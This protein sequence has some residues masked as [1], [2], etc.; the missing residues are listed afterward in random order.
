MD[1]RISEP[2][3]VVE[4]TVISRVKEKLKEVEVYGEKNVTYGP[5]IPYLYETLQC[6]FVFIKRDGRDVTTSLV[7]WHEQKFGTIYRE[8]KDPGDLSQIAIASVAN[9]PVH[10]DTSDYSRPRPPKDDPLHQEWE[11]LTR[12]EMCAYYWACI[13][14]LYMREL[15]K[16]P[17]NMR[18]EVD[19]SNVTADDIMAVAEFCGLQGI[20][21]DTAQKI[22]DKKINS[23]SCRGNSSGTY[24]EW[25]NWD[26]GIRRRFDR[27]AFKTMYQLGYYK[28]K[29]TE[30]RPSHYGNWWRDHDGGIEWY[31]WMYNSRIS[32]HQDFVN[33]VNQRDNNGDEI[34]SIAD[35]GCGLGV[36]Y[37]DVFSGKRYIGVDLSEK[38][39]QWCKEN[40]KNEKHEYLCIDF[41]TEDLKERVDLVFSSGTID[42]TYD[43]NAFIK[44]MV[45]NSKKWIY[46]TSYRGWFPDLTEHVYSYDEG[47]TCF[48]ND[49]SPGKVRMLLESMGCVD[50]DVA[51]LATGDKDIPFETRIIARVQS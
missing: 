9:L 8:C 25:K 13:N 39:I 49:I 41:V 36:G 38:N 47:T 20:K 21:K 46:L 16:I 2:M 28:N 48:Y 4:G 15:R 26:S 18:I 31:T 17:N 6:K 34:L 3:A 43:I 5:F 33:W 27:I 45:R 22:L 12:A 1:G 42:N 32:I 19:Y 44:A 29:G 7:N 37:C 51:P 35:F 40:R 11:S 14:E 50:I 24:P 23:L 30:W 10:M